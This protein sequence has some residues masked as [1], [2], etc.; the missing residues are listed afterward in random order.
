M[1]FPGTVNSFLEV[2]LIL[3]TL[4]YNKNKPNPINY[5]SGN[6]NCVKII[7]G[8][9]LTCVNLHAYITALIIA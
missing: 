6:I 3:I 1:D 2:T 8:H 7:E 4:V 5:Y 9:G